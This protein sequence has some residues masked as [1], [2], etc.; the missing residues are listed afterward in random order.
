MS[1]ISKKTEIKRII[2]KKTRTNFTAR[3]TFSGVAFHVPAQR[4]LM[5]SALLCVFKLIASII[6]ESR[7]ERRYF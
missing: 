6:Y 7:G 3:V 5:I 4:N 2:I 1:H